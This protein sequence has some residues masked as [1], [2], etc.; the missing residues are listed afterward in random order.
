MN[1]ATVAPLPAAALMGATAMH[2]GEQAIDP[3]NY[4]NGSVPALSRGGA[5]RPTTSMFL[6][7]RKPGILVKF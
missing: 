2:A 5:L 7:G 3:S 4:T 1:V 6:P